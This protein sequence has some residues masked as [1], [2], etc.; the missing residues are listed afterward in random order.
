MEEE[1]IEPFYQSEAKNI[2]DNL[3]DNKLFRDG[4]TRDHIK[5]IED[6]IAYYFQSHARMVIK[7]TELKMR[8]KK[9]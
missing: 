3:F 9:L 2:V 4:V 7:S 1:K 8:Y 5:C 6:L